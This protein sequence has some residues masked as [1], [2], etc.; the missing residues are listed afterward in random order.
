MAVLGAASAVLLTMP[1]TGHASD[2]IAKV[3]AK[4]DAEQGQL[5]KL[6]KIFEQEV[7]KKQMVAAQ[8]GEKVQNAVN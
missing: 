3:Q 6:E 1:P 2:F 4:K 5:S 8:V 7:A